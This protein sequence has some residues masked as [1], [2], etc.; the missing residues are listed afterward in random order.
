LLVTGFGLGLVLKAAM[1]GHAGM[2]DMLAY[3]EWGEH[4]LAEGVPQ[5]YHGIYFPLQYQIFQLSAWLVRVTGADSVLIFKT[6]NLLF[7]TG[8]FFVLLGLLDRHG[9]SP[10]YALLYWLHPFFLAMFSLGY[11]DFHFTFFVVLCLYCL[12]DASV[13]SYLLGG[14][15]LG[16]AFMMKPQAQVLIVVA[17]LYAVFRGV[18]RRDWRPVAFLTG[19]IILFGLYEAWFLVSLA[20]TL[21]D[22]A[23]ALL[24]E[25]YLGVVNVMP[26]LNAQLPNTWYPIAYWMKETADPIYAVHDQWRLM[27]VRVK[28]LAA[29]SVLTVV[30]FHVS[31]I[32]RRI[33]AGPREA[34]TAMFCFASLVVPFLMTSAH[35]N[36]LFLGAALLI[37]LIA[38]PLPRSFMLSA[39]V[40][41]LVQALNLFGLFGEYPTWLAQPLRNTFSQELVV[42][43]S[44]I[45]VVSFAIMCRTFFSARIAER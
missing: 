35:E 45:S 44:V 10:L 29:A 25:S 2:Y 20:P 23:R 38:R 3:R 4:A 8:T 5:T 15:P 33:G 18:R 37:P 42:V 30:G 14:I 34:F 19:P 24:P 43:Y 11:I 39:S 28:F 40:L 12:T 26:A 13:G 22:H 27:N 17:F 36:H 1:L 21:G 31:A 16:L 9:S 32:E 41:L 6:S 7:D